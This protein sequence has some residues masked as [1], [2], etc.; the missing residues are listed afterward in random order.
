MHARYQRYLL[1]HACRYQTHTH[2]CASVENTCIEHITYKNIHTY[3]YIYIYIYIHIYVTEVENGQ[4]PSEQK[5]SW[6]WSHTC[7]VK[8]SSPPWKLFTSSRPLVAAKKKAPKRTRRCT[9][10]PH[11]GVP[12]PHTFKV[13]PPHCDPPS[14]RHSG[15]CSSQPLETARLENVVDQSVYSSEH[16]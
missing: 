11:Q 5:A 2:V 13:H 3:I 9:S 1:V 6:W 12:A 16:L 7:Y 10:L 15:P 8:S 4:T 14:F